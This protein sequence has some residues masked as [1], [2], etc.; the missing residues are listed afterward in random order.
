MQHIC[1]E[2]GLDWQTLR[3]EL[4]VE[5]LPRLL[6]HENASAPVVLQGSAS[7]AHHLEDLHDGVIDVSVFPAFIILNTHDYY[8]ITSDGETPSGVLVNVSPYLHGEYAETYP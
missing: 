8:H 4:L 5:L 1:W 7:S 2:M 6:T 3:Q